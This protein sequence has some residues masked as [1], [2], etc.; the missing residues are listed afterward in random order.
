M[1]TF[2]VG[3]ALWVWAD[4]RQFEPLTA[5]VAMESLF[6]WAALGWIPCLGV[7]GLFAGFEVLLGRHRGARKRYGGILVAVALGLTA[8]WARSIEVP[9]DVRSIRIDTAMYAKSI[10]RA[11]EAAEPGEVGAYL[12]EY[13]A[14]RS[15][16]VALKTLERRRESLR[17][18]ESWKDE[19]LAAVEVAAQEALKSSHR[20]LRA[21]ALETLIWAKLEGLAP[22]EMDGLLQAEE[23]PPSTVIDWLTDWEKPGRPALEGRLNSEDLADVEDWSAGQMPA[24]L[25]ALRWALEQSGEGAVASFLARER[26][27]RDTAEVM[28]AWCTTEGWSP[29]LEESGPTA[30][31]RVA[32]DAALARLAQAEDPIVRREAVVHQEW[33]KRMVRV[34][35]Q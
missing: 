4:L 26:P 12:E 21:L 20:P 1:A 25:P 30:A 28:R 13:Y 34:R 35:P 22:G 19:D 11:G 17:A 10:V 31:D 8:M 16:Y 24:G 15:M 33:V 2:F 6:M 27:D 14:P 29:L 5:F 23:I 18:G 32:L 7:G 3:G 9:V